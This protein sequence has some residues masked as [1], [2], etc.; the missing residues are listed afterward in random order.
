MTERGY[1]QEFPA[2]TISPM[3]GLER[4]MEVQPR[5]NA[6]WYAGS[7]KLRNKVA[8]ITG[9][10]SGIGRSVAILYAREGASVAIS[11]L[12]HEQPDADK[13]KQL[14]E[15]EGSKCLLLP[16]DIRDRGHC[17]NIVNRVRYTYVIH[18]GGY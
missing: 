2:Q 3:P 6:D 1:P 10:D 12:E 15:K 9:G 7:G 16:G 13:T 17:F 18:C 11:Y 4:D 5:Y 8:L 14:I